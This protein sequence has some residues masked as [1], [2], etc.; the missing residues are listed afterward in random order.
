[1]NKLEELVTMIPETSHLCDKLNNCYYT[2]ANCTSLDVVG[3]YIELLEKKLKEAERMREVK[4]IEAQGNSEDC[5]S[6]L[7]IQTAWLKVGEKIPEDW[8][9]LTGNDEESLISRVIL[10]AEL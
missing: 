5:M 3:E 7:I 6:D 8:R 4:N 2:D 10:R 1:M 9:V